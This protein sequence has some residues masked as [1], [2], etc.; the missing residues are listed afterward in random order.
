MTDRSAVEGIVFNIQKYSL[1]D[2]PGIRTVVFLK[3]CPLR[4]AWCSNPESQAPQPQLALDRARCLGVDACARCLGRCPRGA[5]GVGADGRIVRDPAACDDCLA[6]AAAC[7]A[8]ALCVYGR[9]VTVGEVLRRVE[10]DEVFYARSGGGLTLSG[11]EPLAQAGFCMALLEEARRRRLGTALETCGHAPWPVLEAAAGLL[12]GVLYDLK[13]MDR[14]RHLRTTGVSNEG[15]LDNLVRLKAAFPRLPLTVRTPV[16]PGFNDREEGGNF[17]GLEPADLLACLTE[18]A[19]FV[20]EGRV[21]GIRFSTR[22]DTVTPE[23]LDR[24]APFPVATVEL[25]VQSMDDGVLG[26]NRRGHT[27]RES[28]SAVA[29]LRERGYEVG[30]QMMVGLPGDD[31]EGAMA[32]GRRIAALAPDFVRIYPT[33]V[34]AGTELARWYA[35][36]RYCPPALDACVDLVARLFA[37]FDGH[38]IRVARM[39]LQAAPGLGP[40][41]VAGPYHPAFGHLVHARIFLGMAASAVRELFAGGAPAPRALCLRVS[42]GDESRM[43]GLR[44]GNLRALGDMFSGIAIRVRADAS[45]APGTLRAAFQAG[46]DP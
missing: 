45:V 8:Q 11:G 14:Q 42:P 29:A 38:G 21:D 22:P 46:A 5:L 7:P 33:L 4:C 40:A 30:C 28:V 10:E 1:H 36:A 31:D 17:L 37:L 34:L 12:D 6:C 24:I 26:L 18:A 3:G 25:G 41:L 35:E 27:A 9:R 43:R 20:R 2:G 13:C 32:S 15:I 16:V 19:R 44:N 39:G 23:R